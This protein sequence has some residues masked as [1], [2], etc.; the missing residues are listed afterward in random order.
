[1][2]RIL[3]LLMA[4]QASTR[5]LAQNDPAE[6]ADRWLFA[7]GAEPVLIIDAVKGTIVEANPAAAVLLNV[8]R[9]GL[10]GTRFLDIFLPSSAQTLE[11]ALVLATTTGA[12]GRLTLSVPGT[13]ATLD[14]SLSLVRKESAAYWLARL[15]PTTVAEQEV[16]SSSV[17]F[18]ALEIATQGFIVTDTGLTIEFANDAFLELTKAG[19]SD[20]VIGQSIVQWLELSEA[21]LKQLRSQMLERQAVTE[22]VTTLR[23]NQG[24]ALNVL[25]HAVAVPDGEHACWGFVL[26]ALETSQSMPTVA[27]AANGGSSRH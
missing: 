15:G 18:E 26:R 25:V 11:Q 27:R 19:S 24:L 2:Q 17:V 7:L 1:M 23:C 16:A 4:A 3:E 9:K 22:L 13:S 10:V 20:H 14:V 8:R 21:Q 12:T 5:P 6:P